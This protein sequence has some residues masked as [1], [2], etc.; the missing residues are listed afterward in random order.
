[1][2]ETFPF[3]GNVTT[4]WC[5]CSQFALS[6]KL[7]ASSSSRLI[8]HDWERSYYKPMVTEVGYRLEKEDTKNRRHLAILLPPLNYNAE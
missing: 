6:E 1:M 5:Y 4:G 3:L 8:I 2:R 7:L